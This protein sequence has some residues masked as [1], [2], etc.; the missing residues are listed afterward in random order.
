MKFPKKLKF[1]KYFK[2][3]L[4]NKS[5]FTLTKSRVLK[6]KIGL[7]VLE[8]GKLKNSEIE[9]CR[10]SIRRMSKRRKRI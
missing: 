7:Q 4:S 8:Q 6:G 10:I 9:S 2:T 1:K 3:K 5:L